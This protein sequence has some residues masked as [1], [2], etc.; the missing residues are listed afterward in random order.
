VGHLSSLLKD[1]DGRDLTRLDEYRAVGG[2]TAVEKARA[3]TPEALVEEMGKP[4]LLADPRFVTMADR[5]A[6]QD[7]LDEIIATWTAP[8]RRFDIMDRLQR[9]GVIATVVETAEDRVE[10]DPQLRHRNLYPLIQHP[11]VGEFAYEALPPKFSRT[12][13]D[14]SLRGPAVHEHDDYVFGDILGL[15]EREMSDL[16]AEGVI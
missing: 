10:Y 4:E 11:E 8:R 7:V 6:N 9:V 15:S 16:R 5:V 14:N 2:Y 1:A 3:M 12:P 13:P